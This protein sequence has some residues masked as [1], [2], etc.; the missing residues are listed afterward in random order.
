MQ[1]DVVVLTVYNRPRR[2]LEN[3]L[4]Q[5]AKCEMADT[6]VLIVDDG[7]D[8][9][10][11]EQ[12]SA[13]LDSGVMAGIEFTWMQADTVKDIPGTYNID[14]HN[15]P[16]YVNNLA[17]EAAGGCERLFFLSSD[18]LIPKQAMTA[19]RDA[20]DRGVVFTPTVLDM[21]TSEAF[22]SPA[23]VWPMMW[24]CA[25]PYE[26]VAD[27]G[28][29]DE[30][31]LMG[32]AFEDND[33]IGRLALACGKL[34]SWGNVICIHQSHSQVAYSDKLEGFKRSEAYCTKK[35]EGAIPWRQN[36]EPLTWQGAVDKNVG[37]FVVE[38]VVYE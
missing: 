33:F 27:C 36:G 21:D 32:M 25:A 28:A 38:R 17:I 31:F 5:L 2:V 23:R 6:L 20:V 16:A 35:W 3:T 29:F 14:G 30:E 7:S 13:M 24:F 8:A 11:K 37:R 26:K 19:A 22:T 10:Y 34:E 4:R 15:N 12:Y 1:R 9:V 18:V